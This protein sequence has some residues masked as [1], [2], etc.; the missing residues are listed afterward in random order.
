MPVT[1]NDVRAFKERGERFP[2]LTAYDALSA[3]LLDEAGIPLLLVGDSLSMVVL[4]HDSTVP[5]TVEEMIHHTRAVAR[6]VTNAMVIGD[7]PFMSYQGSSDE[8]MRNAG[9]FLKEGGA[10]AVKLEGGDRIVDLVG[11]LTDAGIPVMGHLGLT[12]QSVNQFGGYRVQGRTEE[13][14]HRIIREAKDLQAAG[15]FAVVLEAVPAPVAAQVTSTLSIPTIG[16]GAGPSCDGQVLVFH[17]F[18]GITPGPL[19]R[20]V[21]RYAELGSAITEAARTFA[22][23]VAKGVYPSEE[24]TYG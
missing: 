22:D 10:N 17:D 6:G 5:V 3:G 9:R 12:P 19:P 24:H 1:I 16:I 21:K 18:L 23:E 11:R 4:G 13:A 15:A 8:G 2:M 7:M 20:F 14:A